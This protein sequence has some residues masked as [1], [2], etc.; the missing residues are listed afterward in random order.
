MLVDLG[1]KQVRLRQLDSLLE[2]FWSEEVFHCWFNCIFVWWHETGN[3][4]GNK[5]A[6]QSLA[7]PVLWLVSVKADVLLYNCKLGKCWACTEV[8]SRYMP[9]YPLYIEVY[10]NWIDTTPCSN[11]SGN[12]FLSKDGELSEKT[13]MLNYR[14]R[15]ICAQVQH[16][17]PSHQQS[18][19]RIKTGQLKSS[20]EM[21][22]QTL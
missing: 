2:A 22:K 9:I 12:S 17:S 15:K 4:V 19:Q 11:Y 21:T 8:Y 20:K 6:N 13:A 18:R 7:T 16:H 5:V 1:C 10:S 3:V 14:S